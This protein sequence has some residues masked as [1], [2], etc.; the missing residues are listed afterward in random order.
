MR[1]MT[2][3]ARVCLV[4]IAIHLVLSAVVFI[5]APPYE[6]IAWAMVAA[7]VLGA[8]IVRYTALTRAWQALLCL[9]VGLAATIAGLCLHVV[10]IVVAGFSASDV[11]GLAMLAAG[12]GLTIAGSMELVLCIR[13]WWRRLLLVPA[14]IVLFLMVL[15]PV[16]LGVYATNVALKHCCDET[17]ATRGFE[18]EDVRFETPGGIELAAWYV[19]GSNGA[20]VIVVHGSGNNRSHVLDEASVLASHGYGVLMLDIQGFGD[21]EGRANAFGW[22]GARDVHAAVSYLETRPEVDPD[23]IGGLGL[24]MGGEIMLQAAGES[25][26][27]KAI[28]VEGATARTAADV[29]DTAG[30]GFQPIVLFHTVVGLTMKAIS[31]ESTPPALAEMVEQIPPRPVLLIAANLSDEKRANGLFRDIGGPSFELWTIPEAKHTG[32]RELHPE[33]YEQ[34]IIA[35]FDEALMDGTTPGPR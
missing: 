26:A 34:R 2:G 7:L 35:F 20:T 12:A 9:A 1:R 8:I 11:T 15:M 31:G 22:G 17:P 32:A 28:V 24:S 14:A 23:R 16:G 29:G 27:L 25:D 10:R 3:F 21:S 6:R 5:E 33:E 4:L 18:F 19:R 13:T 30:G